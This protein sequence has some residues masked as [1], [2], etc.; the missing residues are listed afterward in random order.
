M[1]HPAT[2]QAD[3]G[4]IILR[5]GCEMRALKQAAFI[6]LFFIVFNTVGYASSNDL[7]IRPDI[8]YGYATSK[9][10]QRGMG[11]HAG[12]RILSS[13]RSLSST[14]ADKRAGIMISSVS[15]FE[16]KDPLRGRKYLAVG[17]ILEKVLAEHFVITIGTVGYIGTDQNRNNPFGIISEIGW[18]PKIGRRSQLFTAVRIESIYD[19]STVSRY[20]LSGG[21]KF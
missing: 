15:P 4:T 1:Q 19:T 11:Y 8:G 17:I 12:V 21:I 2:V 18:E 5:G 6:G 10:H 16:S 13:V 9:D 14:T 20:S 3:A 7:D